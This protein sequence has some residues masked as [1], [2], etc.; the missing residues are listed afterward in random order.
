MS[1]LDEYADGCR[2]QKGA[3]WYPFLSSGGTGRGAGGVGCLS[4]VSTPKGYKGYKGYKDGLQPESLA[5]GK[6]P[7]K[8]YVPSKRI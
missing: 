7:Q 2:I 5:D 1:G 4:G 3:D 6:P 8:V